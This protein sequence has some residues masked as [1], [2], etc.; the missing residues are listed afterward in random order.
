MY[1]E[2]GEKECGESSEQEL[3]DEQIDESEGNHFQFQF[4]VTFAYRALKFSR[5]ATT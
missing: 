2:K 4:L 3:A 1:F 5:L